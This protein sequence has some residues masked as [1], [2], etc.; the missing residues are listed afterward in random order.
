MSLSCPNCGKDVKVLHVQYECSSGHKWN[1]DVVRPEEAAPA[2]PSTS[3]KMPFGKYK[4]TALEDIP[5]DYIQWCLEK[6]EDLR[7][8][9]KEELENQLLLR[10][11]GGVVRQEVKM[12]GT[13][14]IFGKGKNGPK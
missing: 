1:E 10:K 5:T 3:M 14:V 4:G 7:P 8:E 11:G 6:L 9:L 13:K 12:V 2:P